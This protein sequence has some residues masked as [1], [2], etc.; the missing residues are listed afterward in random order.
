MG[1]V[2]CAYSSIPSPSCGSGLGEM[3]M[4]YMQPMANQ[5]RHGPS[6]TAFSASSS[7]GFMHWPRK[8]SDHHGLG[9]NQPRLASDAVASL[10]PH[11]HGPAVFERHLLRSLRGRLAKAARLDLRV[12]QGAW[13][14]TLHA[15]AFD[16]PLQPRRAHLLE[17]H[18]RLHCLHQPH[19]LRLQSR[20]RRRHHQRLPLRAASPFELCLR[21]A[22]LPCRPAEQR[23]DMC[24]RQPRGTHAARR[25]YYRRFTVSRFTV[26]P[27]AHGA[28]GDAPVGMKHDAKAQRTRLHARAERE[29]PRPQ[30]ER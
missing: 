24:V 13:R 21:A 29:Q 30:R 10:R 7:T 16:A 20:L 17:P 15:L 27:A 12:G 25:H 26:V 2:V 9:H 23:V 19:A 5:V 18:Q 8:G 28:L 3:D 4:G 11:H 1:E 22:R 14:E 6:G